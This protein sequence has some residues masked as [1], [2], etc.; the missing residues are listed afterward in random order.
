MSATLPSRLQPALVPVRNAASPL[1]VS[2]GATAG[3]G[4]GAGCS[5]SSASAANSESASLPPFFF[6]FFSV[7][8]ASPASSPPSPLAAPVPS[9]SAHTKN[10]TELEMHVGGGW[11]RTRATVCYTPCIDSRRASHVRELGRP[12]VC[13]CVY[14]HRLQA[15]PQPML[16]RGCL[17]HEWTSSS[18]LSWLAE[19]ALS[20]PPQHRCLRPLHGRIRAHTHA[21]TF[22]QT[23]T[24]AHKL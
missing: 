11:S 18:S 15:H 21:H 17:R 10:T 5:I 7:L 24:H 9:Q 16:R 4:A 19:P 14:T 2:A 12:R 20:R 8:S 22:V 6:F 3:A 23:R 1:L 13:V